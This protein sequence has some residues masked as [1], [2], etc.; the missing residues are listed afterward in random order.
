M[1]ALRRQ[2]LST[3]LQQQLEPGET[4]VWEEQPSLEIEFRRRGPLYVG[5]FLFAAA[6]FLILQVWGPDNPAVKNFSWG[7][8]GFSVA[9][10]LAAWHV[11]AST[12]YASTLRRIVA[13]RSWT[14]K[15]SL[16]SYSFANLASAT[17][18]EII[19]PGGDLLFPKR[20]S[21]PFG[22]L[23]NLANVRAAYEQLSAIAKTAPL[24]LEPESL[25]D[26]ES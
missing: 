16:Q 17:V 2:R 19:G 11:N 20:A 8:L 9:A 3:K 22:G 10:P 7:F 13:F 14:G 25:E 5:F 21:D 1:I 24:S 15:Q 12:L 6:G 18:S 23:T 4:I 26:E